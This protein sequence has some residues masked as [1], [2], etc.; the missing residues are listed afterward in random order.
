MG[1]VNYYRCFIR[2]FAKIAKP[3]HSLLADPMW[4]VETLD[5]FEQLTQ[6]LVQAPILWRSNWNLEFHVYIDVSK[7]AIGIVLAQPGVKKMT[8]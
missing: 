2:N 8:F 7:Y 5:A 6:Y 1:N 3:I 4:I